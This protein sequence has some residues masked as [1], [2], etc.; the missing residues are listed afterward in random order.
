[1]KESIKDYI[2]D[3]NQ[4]ALDY[5]KSREVDNAYIKQLN[6]QK[7]KENEKKEYTK[8]LESTFAG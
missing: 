6:L 5:I 4:D 7:Q 3:G 8:G 2:Q 1:M